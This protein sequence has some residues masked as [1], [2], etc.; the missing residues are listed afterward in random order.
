MQKLRITVVLKIVMLWSIL[1][2]GQTISSVNPVSGWQGQTIGLTVSGTSLNFVQ[3]TNT[4]V[5]IEQNS[6]IYDADASS[7]Q[8]NQVTANILIPGS[9]PTGLYTV[10]VGSTGASGASLPNGFEVL[11]ALPLLPAPSL[12]QPANASVLN[13][14]PVQFSWNTVP[15]AF[16]YQYQVS[17]SPGF[18]SIAQQGELAST[19]SSAALGN[20]TYYWRVRTK[21]QAGFYGG[22]S[23]SNQFTVQMPTS[24]NSVVPNSGYQGQTLSVTISGTNVSF[25]ASTPTAF[26]FTMGPNTMN[27]WVQEQTVV[28]PPNVDFTGTGSLNIPISIPTGIYDLVYTDPTNTTYSLPQSFTVLPELPPS[29]PVTLIEPINSVVLNSSQVQFDWADVANADRYELWLST[30]AG[31]STTIFASNTITLSQ[32]NRNLPDGVF[33]WRVRARNLSGIWGS[34]SQTEDFT[35]QG[36]SH[37]IE[38]TPNT[39]YAGQ[40]G[41]AV[42]VSGVNLPFVQGTS[43]V[44]DLRLDQNSFQIELDDEH[45]NASNIG[46]GILSIPLNAPVGYYGLTWDLPPYAPVALQNA[47]YINEGNEYSGQAYVDVNQNQTIDAGDVP[48]PYAQVQVMPVT[49]YSTTQSSGN[50]TGHVPSGTHT[51]SLASVSSFTSTPSQHTVS[52]SGSGGIDAGNDFLLQPIAGMHDLSISLA[53]E[54]LRQGRNRFVYVTVR[55]L[56]AEIES[57]EFSVTFETGMSVTSASDPNYTVNGNTVSWNF[58]GL[59]IAQELQVALELYTPITFIV[60]QLVDFVGTV[61]DVS[62]DQTPQDNT[63]LLEN[64]VVNSYDPNYKAVSPEGPLDETFLNGENYLN[65]TV[66]F[67]NTGNAEAID[68]YVLDTISEFLDLSTF[69]FVTASH[70][71]VVNMLN[72]RIIEFRFDNINLPDST[73]NEPESHGYLSYRIKPVSSFGWGDVIRNTAYI[74]FDYNEPIITNTTENWIPTGVGERDDDLW[75]TVGPNPNSTGIFNVFCDGRAEYTVYDVQGKVIASGYFSGRSDLNLTDSA[76]GV[77]ILKVEGEKGTSVKKLVRY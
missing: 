55:N 11:P 46:S 4:V 35:V 69:Q 20:N 26:Q 2:T 67:Q 24:L 31:F 63:F 59:G 53:A 37:I 54:P 72:D 49:S 57:G 48:Y 77:F 47:F 34:W 45:L 13:A 19:S 75:F 52:F 7:V 73:S 76:V 60:G 71:R 23:S 51:L 32:Y 30:D 25:I 5:W 1:C 70:D 56:G 15:D 44:Q 50:F 61:S 27:V 41:L 28:N 18:S 65:F 62:N 74:Y 29:G 58:S 39:G 9:A 6:N 68:V 21:N 16:G 14:N 40:S 42:T 64:Q 10:H 43:V 22:W 8:N 33:Y 36:V 38:M 3:G 17:I 66:H 12:I